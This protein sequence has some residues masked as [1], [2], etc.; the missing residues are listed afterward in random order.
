VLAPFDETSPFISPSE[1]SLGD[2]F[3]RCPAEN[4]RSRIKCSGASQNIEFQQVTLDTISTI[5]FRNREPIHC[6]G[7]RSEYDVLRALKRLDQ[8]RDR[9][10]IDQTVFMAINKFN[11]YYH[12]MV[13][14]IP[15]IA[16]YQLCPEFSEGV[17]LL[18]AAQSID[19]VMCQSIELATNGLPRAR[20][21]AAERTPLALNHLI[22]SSFI[23]PQPHWSRFAGYVYDKMRRQVCPQKPQP[24]RCIYV[25]RPV[26]LRSP[27]A[28]EDK[29]VALLLRFG[30]EAIDPGTLP[31]TEQIKI[32]HEAK[33]IIG[34]HGAGLT[35]V[36]FSQPG[37]LLYELFP[38]V[39]LSNVC[40]NR[41]AQGRGVHYWA[42]VFHCPTPPL[43]G[44]LGLRQTPWQVDL[45]VIERRLEQI[46]SKLF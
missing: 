36:I 13:E 29:L 17:L 11:N 22:F 31:L 37:A 19:D 8:P 14:M 42:D 12:W 25:S 28:N 18:T 33:L 1:I 16:G 5:V 7:Y 39:A 45:D 6:G 40:Y 46:K 3:D 32:F 34:T 4:L 41:L 10:F 26:A 43:Q 30:I 2:T 44:L 27:L 38:S 20:V 23:H 21:Y 35:N 24:F 9:R 15:A